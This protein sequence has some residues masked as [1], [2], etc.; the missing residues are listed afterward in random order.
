MLHL[1][2][3]YYMG[4]EVLSEEKIQTYRDEEHDLLMRIRNGEFLDDNKQPVKE[5]YDMLD[6]LDKELVEAYR[7]SKLPEEPRYK[8]IKELLYSI[9]HDVVV[10]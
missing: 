9:L 7:S 8:E 6:E 10:K 2:R 5:F 4:I 1:I 3:L